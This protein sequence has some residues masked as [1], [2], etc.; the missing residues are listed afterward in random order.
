MKLIFLRR[1][2]A[3]VLCLKDISGFGDVIKTKGD[4]KVTYI[5]G[6]SCGIKNEIKYLEEMP[7]N[8]QPCSII[9][10]KT[11]DKIGELPPSAFSK[12]KIQ[13]FYSDF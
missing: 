9:I 8:P 4:D 12:C 11:K 10:E 7:S 2:L 3:F 13:D 5:S 1:I 6:E